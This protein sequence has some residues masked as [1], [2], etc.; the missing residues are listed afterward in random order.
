MLAQELDLDPWNFQ[1]HPEVW[2]LV[3]FL[4]LAYIYMVR[5]I[6]PNAVAPGTPVV[7]RGNTYAFIAAMAM[8]WVASDW[9]LHDIS[10]EYLYSAHMLQH[11]MLSYFLPPLA[12]MATPLMSCLDDILAEGDDDLREFG[13]VE[14]KTPSDSMTRCFAHALLSAARQPLCA[15][16]HGDCDTSANSESCGSSTNSA[17][18]CDPCSHSRG[19]K[20][21][22]RRGRRG[23]GRGGIQ[24][25]SGSPNQW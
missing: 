23:R 10:E 11:M 8:L 15:V 13:H 16:V 19:P 12:L 5:V 18:S 21:K 25:F 4:T 6:G 17:D 3:G 24:K 7:T 22:T 9:P 20:K 14:W 2:L 1:W